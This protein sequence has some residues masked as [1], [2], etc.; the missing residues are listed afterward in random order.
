M[1]VG[2]AKIRR[3][4]TGSWRSCHAAMELCNSSRIATD[5]CDIFFNPKR[6]VGKI[7]VDPSRTSI[8]KASTFKA[9]RKRLCPIQP[10]N[11]FFPFLSLCIVCS[12]L[13]VIVR[14]KHTDVRLFLSPN[15]FSCKCSRDLFPTE[16]K[17][18]VSIA[19]FLAVNQRADYCCVDLLCKYSL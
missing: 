16:S 5:R 8:L 10:L 1:A 17:S 12:V 13:R 11:H 6:R 14:W 19:E 9:V 2:I 18:N 3:S 4:D 7:Q 15:I